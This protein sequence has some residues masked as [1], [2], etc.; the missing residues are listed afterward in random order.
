MST[1][2]HRAVG[3]IVAHIAQAC[4]IV[5]HMHRVK[6]VR[7]CATKRAVAGAVDVEWVG[8]QEDG[9]V[10]S[11]PPCVAYTGAI[12]ASPLTRTAVVCKDIADPLPAHS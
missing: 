12:E 5:T 9:A 10:D 4:A 11:R 8:Y 1:P 2:V 7:A 6:D 3:A